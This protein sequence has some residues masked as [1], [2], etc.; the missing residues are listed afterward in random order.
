MSV[1]PNPGRTLPA[2][3]LA[4]LRRR[5][6]I[7][8]PTRLARFLQNYGQPLPLSTVG[9]YALTGLARDE[10]DAV[11]AEALRLGLVEQCTADWP[12]HGRYGR[13]PKSAIVPAIR[14]TTGKAV[15]R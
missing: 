2:G 8:G 13:A 14:A 6:V 11:I 9:H 10:V 7:Q 3:E 12:R 5:W 1:Y 15:A 4:A